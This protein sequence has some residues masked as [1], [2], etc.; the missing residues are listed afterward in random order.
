MSDETAMA[1]AIAADQ[2]SEA[3][4]RI[5]ELEAA[6][7]HEAR[8]GLAL[9]ERIEKLEGMIDTHRTIICHRDHPR[10]WTEADIALWKALES[11]E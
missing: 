7:N 4:R 9:S 5:A 11:G 10:G 8:A 3:H 6:L 2:L 1:L